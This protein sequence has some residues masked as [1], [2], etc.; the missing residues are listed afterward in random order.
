MADPFKSGDKVKKSGIY[1]V[2]HDGKHASA[3]EVTC[4]AGKT[5]PACGECG[6]AV[7]F[8]LVKHATHIGRSEHFK[9]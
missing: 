4:I 3:H 1:S 2:L 8:L 5:F 9:L 6:D 7:R